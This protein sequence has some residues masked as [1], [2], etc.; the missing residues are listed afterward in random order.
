MTIIFKASTTEA[1]RIKILS[2]LLKNNL[3]RFCFVIDESGIKTRMMDDN[4]SVMF[5][6]VL[7]QP[8]FTT[9]KFKSSQPICC[10]INSSLLQ[11]MLRSIKKKDTVYLF[12]DDSAPF[13][14][15]IKVVPKDNNRI[16]SSFVQTQE[17]Q[18]IEISLPEGYPK[19]PVIVQSSE[20]QK[21]C[22]DL[23]HIGKV[24]TVTSKGFSIKFACGAKG[25]VSRIE[26]FGVEDSDGDDDD[27]EQ[28]E[29]QQ[30]FATEQFTKIAKISGLGSSMR[31]FASMGVPLK[32]CANIG[33]LGEIS[34]YIKSKEQI[35]EDSCDA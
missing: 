16:T 5:D 10:G 28:K 22:K 1:Y 25:V 19:S 14:L 30:T 26:Q 23:S 27:F 3:S 4:R 33:D 2:D 6:F 20:F 15:G 8:K 24:I 29:Y 21:M 18:N 31:I 34:I 13:D 9:W 17:M 12:I 11:K 7:E 35:D 32:F